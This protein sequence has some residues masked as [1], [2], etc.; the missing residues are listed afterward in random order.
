MIDKKVFVV[1]ID[2][3]S[4]SGKSSVSR[5]LARRHGWVWVS[6]GA[7]YRGLAV[8]ARELGVA[9]SDVAKLSALADDERWQVVL[10][11]DRTR[12]L[13][14]G[15][16][17]TDQVYREDIGNAASTISQ[18]PAVRSRLLEGQRRCAKGVAGLVAEGR[19]CGTVVFPDAPVKI[20][21]TAHSEHRFERRAREEGR[22]VEETR[23]AQTQRDLQDSTRAS[24]PLQV[25]P[26]AVVI[27]TSHLDLPGVVNKVDDLVKAA[28][29][30]WK[31]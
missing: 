19:D 10:A 31:N 7:F 30:S 18:I 15:K 29:A 21:L 2:G 22:S 4:A 27:D 13:L 11:D 6:T 28:L 14:D 12:V 16:D 8:V 17:V 3:P 1:A 23:A 9:T 25:A 5:E 20:Y 26:G 24:A